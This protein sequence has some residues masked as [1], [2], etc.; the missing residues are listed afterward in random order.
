MI[1]KLTISLSPIG[2][3]V[4]NLPGIDNSFR[5]IKLQE[6]SKFTLAVG[7]AIECIKAFQ[8]FQELE[9]EYNLLASRTTHVGSKQEKEKLVAFNRLNVA[10]LKMENANLVIA[11][12][13]NV[14]SSNDTTT[15]IISKILDGQVSNKSK[16][17][18]DG[19]PTEQQIRHWEKH[20]GSFGDPTCPF[21]ISEG[22]F[23][24]GKNR[25]ISLKNLSEYEALRLGLISRGFL[26]VK[27]KD[28]NPKSTTTW[29]KQNM[30]NIYLFSNGNLQDH[31]RV[32]WS[33]ENK[34]N[35]LRDGKAYAKV[36]GY[37]PVEIIK[38]K[39]CVVKKQTKMV[40][41]TQIERAIAKVG[42]LNF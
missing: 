17:G 1:P 16:L 22:R 31:K 10:K 34:E 35:L 25:E 3:L 32:G 26:E 2:D 39:G 23:E 15:G 4:A 33:K 5:K 24:K 29:T 37:K 42:K 18:E 28:L 27:P 40:K 14:I 8:N 13:S 11:A 20:S 6:T 38:K 9:F 21:C 12:L 7:N 36:H 19:N 30:G 41:E